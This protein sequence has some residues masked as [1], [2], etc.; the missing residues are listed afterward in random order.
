MRR[1]LLALLLSLGACLAL[2]GSAFSTGPGGWNHIGATATPALNGHVTALHRFGTV[3][4]LGGN[5]TNAGGIANADR[6]VKWD[7]ISWHGLGT[8]PLGN[9]SVFAI[10]HYGGKIYAGGTFVNAGGK[11]AADYL[12]VFDGTSWKPF[13]N[14]TPDPAFDSAGLQVR[15]LQVV[16]STLYVGGTFQNANGDKR[17][18]YLIACDLATG[19]PRPTVDTDGDFTGAVYALAATSDG[20]LYAGGTFTNLDRLTTADGVAAYTPDGG[21]QGL[22]ASPIGGI[23][24]GLHAK[25]TDLYIS[26]DG[27]NIGG[28]AQADHL[29]KWDGSGYTAVGS[30]TAG[31]NGYF[32]STTYINALTS[33]GPLLFAAGSWQ[34]ANGQPTADVV[35]YFDG[36]SWRA[37]GS[38]GHGNGPWVGDTQ[39]LEVVNGQLYAGGALT[40]AGGDKQAN[41][42]TSRSLRLPD[43]EIG[44]STG[45]YVGNDVYNVTGAGQTKTMSIPRGTSKF[46]PVLVQNDGPLPASYK[47]KGAGAAPGHSVTYI[48]YANGA[49]ITTAVRNGTFSTGELARGQSFAMKMIV[50]LTATAAKNAVFT[51]TAS[52]TAG[53]PPDVVKGI[54]RAT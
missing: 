50:K 48:N 33:S 39:A 19:A 4:Y 36:T 8:T 16:G 25:G 35:A 44:I 47:V 52:S 29:V 37:L 15:A 17:A 11:A 34:N 32:P 45:N 14:S 18:D 49:N 7:G 12:A 43:A 27:L 54:V 41:F 30:N 10:A 13:C 31:T 51:V 5:F 2:S 20:T 21:W 9:G 6:I 1:S 53:T 22:G 24:R 46:F 26:S 42:A 3:L 28:I 38:N 23:V 40:A